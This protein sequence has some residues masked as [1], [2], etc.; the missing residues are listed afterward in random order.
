MRL[1]P[2][3]ALALALALAFALAGCAGSIAPYD[4]AGEP[5]RRAA[6]EAGLRAKLGEAWDQ[7][8]PGLAEADLE[9]GREV[10]YKNCDA[11][12]G[13]H[14]QGDGPRADRMQPRPT[15]LL[16]GR[17][18]S[19]AGELQL[20]RDGSPGT[21]MPGFGGKLPDRHILAVYRYLG[22]LRANPPPPPD[23]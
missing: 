13:A 1:A 22:W 23:E 15:N 3:R 17:T 10:W 20:L 14:G 8:V 7:P 21:G 9:L 18:L 16:A 19:Q 5:A 6:L 11:C 4:P 2:A 12:H